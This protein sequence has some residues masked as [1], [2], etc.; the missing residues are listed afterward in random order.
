MNMVLYS[1][2]RTV[3]NKYSAASLPPVPSNNEKTGYGHILLQ[4]TA[5]LFD[6]LNIED[7]TY[8]SKSKSPISIESA[9]QVHEFHDLLLVKL[10]VS[11]CS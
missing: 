11:G 1:A 10:I 2:L 4:K 8:A 9:G 7:A 5:F 6:T 3:I